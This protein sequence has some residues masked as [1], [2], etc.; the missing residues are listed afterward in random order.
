MSKETKSSA[1]EKAA[2]PVN[3]QPVKAS[4]PA[5][6]SYSASEI[7]QNA[8]R[9]FGYSADVAS[10]ALNRSKIKSCTLSEAKRI[11]KD[12]AERKV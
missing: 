7:A 11:I 3:A 9:L 5:E 8:P 4:P 6:S 2:Q 12:F 10:A 1:P